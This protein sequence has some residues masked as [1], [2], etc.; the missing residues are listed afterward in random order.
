MHRHTELDQPLTLALPDHVLCPICGKVTTSVHERAELVVFEHDHGWY[1]RIKTYM[2]C[3][4]RVP[5][6]CL[7]NRL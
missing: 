6:G 5:F 2:P 1:R 4:H 3:G 7:F